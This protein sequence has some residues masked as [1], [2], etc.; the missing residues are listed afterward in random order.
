MCVVSVGIYKWVA[1]CLK[2][3][4]GF[5]RCCWKSF[6]H[7]F[8]ERGLFFDSGI[9]SSCRWTFLITQHQHQRRSGPA[10]DD[11]FGP[12]SVR[13]EGLVGGLGGRRSPSTRWK[14][15]GAVRGSGWGT[16]RLWPSCL[17]RRLQCW[18]RDETLGRIGA[19]G[20]RRGTSGGIRG[21]LE[22]RWGS[23]GP[24]A[25]RGEGRGCEGDGLEVRAAPA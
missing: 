3:T 6:Q 21:G 17:S 1:F 24:G 11:T 23:G 25:S 14:G 4:C 2:M 22:D 8:R 10:K 12:P 5:P 18:S 9:V 20:S 15:R 7:F 16:S 19:R 13:V